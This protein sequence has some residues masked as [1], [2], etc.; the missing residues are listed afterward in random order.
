MTV[1]NWKSGKMQLADAVHNQPEWRLTKVSDW[2]GKHIWGDDN[3]LEQRMITDPE[4]VYGGLLPYLRNSDLRVVNVETVL[5]RVGAPL[6]AKGSPEKRFIDSDEQTVGALTAVP[7]DIGCLAN[8]HIMDRSAE[9]LENTLRVLREAGIRTVG[10]GMNGEDAAAPLLVEVKGVPV[11]IINCS[12]GEQCRSQNNGPGAYGLDLHQIQQ[13]VEALKADGAVVIVIFHGGREHIPVP[14]PY[15]VR[16][17]RS[18]AEMGVSAVI[19]H[20]PHTPQGIEV[21]QGVPIVYSLGNFVFWQEETSFYRHAGY[22]LHLD[23]S[24]THLIGLEITP[25]HVKRDGVDLMGERMRERFAAD[26][27][28]V[29]AILQHPDQ[30]EAVWDAF[31][32]RL[33]QDYFI[34]SLESGSQAIQTGNKPGLSHLRNLFFTPAHRELFIRGIGRIMDGSLGHAPAWSKQLVTEWLTYSYKEALKLDQ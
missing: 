14:P 16:D 19:A 23:F 33:G 24:G 30:I 25:Y 21:H 6:A 7:F 9:G 5:G 22:A 13:Q 18:I 15:V 17:L 8:N 3:I 2:A 20:H 31:M 1:M 29:N 34:R 11:A 27:E 28:R 4:G 32:D 26:M 10:A 12:E